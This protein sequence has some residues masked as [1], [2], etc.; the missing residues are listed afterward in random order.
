MFDSLQLYVLKPARLFC[1]WG[2]PGKNT[3][4]GCHALIATERVHTLRFVGGSRTQWT[5]QVVQIVKNPPAMQE[6]RIQSL[7]QKK[8]P[9][10]GNGYPL[11]HYCLENPLD[12]GTWWGNS[13]W[14]H[15]EAD[16]TERLSKSTR[17]HCRGVLV[18][19]HVD[20][21]QVTSGDVREGSGR[22]ASFQTGCY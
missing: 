9:G 2:S 11:Q 16:M 22:K 10:D 8:P 12:R 7:G 14:S 21:R 3:G 17:R 1:P 19:S 5:S 18:L 4:V 20:M 6:T 15:K 13:P